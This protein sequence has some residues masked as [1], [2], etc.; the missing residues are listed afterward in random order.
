[1]DSV[2]EILHVGTKLQQDFGLLVLRW[3]VFKLVFYS[4]SIGN[5]A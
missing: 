5:S 4:D 3:R 1:M 2:N